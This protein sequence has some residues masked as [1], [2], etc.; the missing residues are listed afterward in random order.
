MSRCLVCMSRT[1]FVVCLVVALLFDGS[2]PSPARA[3]TSQ[4]PP[5]LDTLTITMQLPDNC[6]LEDLGAGNVTGRMSWTDT[7][8][9]SLHINDGEREA[10]YFRLYV[11][12]Q[13]TVSLRVDGQGSSR[14]ILRAANGDIL[15]SDQGPAGNPQRHDASLNETV[16]RGVYVVEVA[17]EYFQ[18]YFGDRWFYLH[19][20]GSGIVKPRNYGLS[21]L[22]ISDVALTAFETATFNYARNVAA[23]VT[24]VTVTPTPAIAGSRVET[25]PSDADSD[26]ADGHQVSLDADGSTEITVKVYSPDVTSADPAVYTVTL[27]E[28]AATTKPLSNDATL[29]T[30]GLSGLDIGTFSADDREYSYTLDFYQAL[31]THTTTV[32]FATTHN[33]ATW[34][35]SPGDADLAT[36]HQVKLRGASNDV[37][38]I[39]VTSQDNEIHRTYT[40]SPEPAIRPDASK[41]VCTRCNLPFVHKSPPFHSGLWVNGDRFTVGM[42]YGQARPQFR[43]LD[44]NGQRVHSFQVRS[45]SSWDERINGVVYPESF[46]TGGETLYVV[47]R[48]SNTIRAYSLE[49][50]QWLPGKDVRIDSGTA[51]NLW[52]DGTTMYVTQSSTLDKLKMY[53]LST[54][55]RTGTIQ[56]AGSTHGRNQSIWSDGTTL[57]RAT[58]DAEVLAYSLETGARIPG[59]DIRTGGDAE[60]FWSDGETFW[61]LELGERV[62]YTDFAHNIKAYTLPENARLKH[63]SLDVGRIGLFYNGLFDYE[64]V[65]PAGTTEVTVTALAAFT[66]GSSE[67][68][69]VPTDA[70]ANTAGHQVSLDTTGDTTITVNVTAPNGTHQE[71]YTVTVAVAAN[72]EPSFDN[73][74][75]TLEVREDATASAGE[76]ASFQATDDTVGTLVYSVEGSDKAVIGTTSDALFSWDTDPASPSYG[77][78]TLKPGARLDYETRPSYSVILQ[79]S[80]GLSDLDAPDSAI[81]DTMALMIVVANV[82]EPGTLSMPPTPSVD[83]LHE[84]ALRDPDGGINV[85]SWLWERSSDRD[86]G[87]WTS[88]D[89]VV[90]GSGYRPTSD[91]VGQWLRA[92]GT[93]TDDAAPSTPKT[94]TA[95]STNPV[96]DT[97]SAPQGR[98]GGP[99]G[100]GGGGGGGGPVGGGGGGG[101]PVGGGGFGDAEGED[102]G[103]AT[104]P[105]SFADVDAQ[106]VHALNIQA[107]AAAG[108]T[109]GCATEPL[110]YCPDQPVRRAQM[111]T[112]L[113]QALNLEPPDQPAGFTDVD[114]QSVH[115]LNI[116]ALAAAGITVGCATEPLRYCPDQP[117]RRAQMAT[118][119]V[120]ALNLEPPDQPAGFTDV[121]PQSVH[122]LNIEALAAAGITV[123]CATEPLR[124][125]PDQPVR[126]AQMATFLVRALNL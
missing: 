36:G 89:Q 25:T 10:R 82:D 104:S 41:T 76:L 12:E 13:S 87:P 5:A 15:A 120:R 103:P 4:D 72:V 7:D 97:P 51:E 8:C 94:L 121:D 71:T 91:D 48:W 33:A 60:A 18:R 42:G 108:I 74:T 16:A 3:L 81:D 78:L 64:A 27:T 20:E 50:K 14:L 124:Y 118:F 107:L 95:R 105:I 83:A 59:L 96:Q 114:P 106:S 31:N 85:V 21:A 77:A 39:T 17:S 61:V 73:S 117:V 49:S 100:G 79:V 99:V 116:E 66:G 80:D 1:V 56:L 24:E 112:F 102:D 62:S 43:V 86:A 22:T 58:Y 19:H 115:A 101:G 28:L 67:V 57:W 9:L 110:R 84:A 75:T 35:I 40:V 92:T 113:A 46:W 90:S 53:D 52:S 123:G 34:R 26:A 65:V 63:L 111:A 122:A 69:I 119:L 126:R 44:V 37:V 54:K 125:C 55:Q 47:F 11:R 6:E 30:L 93:Y 98:V 23:D 68:E 109:V 29:S 2:A 38:T 70:D 32:S 88:I 45:E